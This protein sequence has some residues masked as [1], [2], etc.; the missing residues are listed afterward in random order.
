MGAIIIKYLQV[1]IY[2]YICTNTLL[3]YDF[4]FLSHRKKYLNNIIT[5]SLFRNVIKI[6]I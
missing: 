4:I 2:I 6:I 5:T 1:Y 3:I